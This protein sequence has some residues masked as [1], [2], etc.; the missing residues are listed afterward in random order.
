LIPPAY[1]LSFALTDLARMIGF[2]LVALLIS[3]W[4]KHSC[5]HNARA[6]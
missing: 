2:V 4:D 5:G 6:I 3:G 1:A